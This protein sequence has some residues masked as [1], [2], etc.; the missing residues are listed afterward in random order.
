MGDARLAAKKKVAGA[1]KEAAA[2]T[3]KVA[4]PKKKAVAASKKAAA[5]EEEGGVK[6]KF[7]RVYHEAS[8]CFWRVRFPDGTSKGFRYASGEPPLQMRQKA[9]DYARECGFSIVE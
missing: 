8:R 3:K 2:P 7:A 9:E 5:A 1:K 4:A 6:R